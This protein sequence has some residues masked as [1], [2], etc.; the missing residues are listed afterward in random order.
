MRGH[1]ERWDGAGHPDGLA[2]EQIPDGAGIL[3]VAEAWSALTSPRPH[4]PARG[5]A[6]AMAELEAHAGTR[7]WPLAVSALARPAAARPRGALEQLILSGEDRADRLVAEHVVHRVG[8]D[9]VDREHAEQVRL[10]GLLGQRHRVG[11]DHLLD[12]R[13]A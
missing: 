2:G 9:P 4:R 6:E 5:P 13:L 12:H 3:A 11:D 1:H 10:G 7:F 8:E